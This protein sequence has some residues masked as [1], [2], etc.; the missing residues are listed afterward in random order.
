[1]TILQLLFYAFSAVLLFSAV[2]VITSR[3]P[4]RSV[5]FLVLTF[6]AASCL[7]MMLQAEFLALVLIFVYVGA[8]MTLF[9]F[10]VM[11]LNIDL[12]P[13]REG[14]VRYLPLGVIVLTLLVALMLFVIGPKQFGISLYQL[15]MQP[16]NYSNV[17]VL[18][19]LLYTQYTYPFEIAGML[20]LVAIIAA[21]SL[22]FRG[23]RNSKSQR[24]AQQVAVKPQ[25]RVR[26]V[27]MKPESK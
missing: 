2:M 25:D 11:M 4:V 15:P 1:M 10:V 27:K 21:I 3:H 22:A 14:F 20:L 5:L 7:W 6:F 12:A 23:R 18:G 26:L 16:A 17:K 8:V 19:E 24:I 9:L 13:L